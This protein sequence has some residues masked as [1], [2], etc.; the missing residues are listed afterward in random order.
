MPA[1]KPQVTLDQF[2]DRFMAFESRVAIRCDQ[3]EQNFK[4]EI[5]R[6]EARIQNVDRNLEKLTGDVETLKQE[7]HAI[8]AGLKRLEVQVS[9]LSG[10]TRSQ[11]LSLKERVL[12]TEDR[13]TALESQ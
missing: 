4:S 8:V 10:E 1:K 12:A 5:A 3:V 2:Y 9:E 6:L 11:L 7:Y 13:I